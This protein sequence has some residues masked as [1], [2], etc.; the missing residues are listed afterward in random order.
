ML[1]ELMLLADPGTDRE[2]LLR[3]FQEAADI[4]PAAGQ[5]NRF[6]LVVGRAEAHLEIGS[7]D[8][9]GSVHVEFEAGDVQQ[10]EGMALRALEL[11]AQLEMRVEDVLW[12]GEITRANL[13]ELRAHWLQQGKS[14]AQK[15]PVAAKPWWRVW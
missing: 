11:A 7:K 13:D 6:R 3:V 15:P 12:G 4:Q 1:Y 5:S 10:M 14:G 2:R 9:V 8:P